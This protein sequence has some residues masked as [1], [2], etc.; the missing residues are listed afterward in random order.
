MTNA[1]GNIAPKRPVSPAAIATGIIVILGAAA[2]GALGVYTDFLW[3]GQLGFESVFTTQ[4]LAQAATFAVA[5]IVMALFTWV[6]FY[7]SYKTRPIYLKFADERDIFA[8]PAR[9]R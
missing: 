7:V 4:I 3:F 5:A 8:P 2:L 1:N 6:G 9:L